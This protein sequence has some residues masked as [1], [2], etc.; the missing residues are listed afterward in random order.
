MKKYHVKKILP[1]IATLFIILTF[2]IVKSFKPKKP[3]IENMTEVSTLFRF[4]GLRNGDAKFYDDNWTVT[5]VAGK[6]TAI[7]FDGEQRITYDDINVRWFSVEKS[8]K[9]IVYSNQDN[10]V[11]ILKLDEDMQVIKN[12]LAFITD[13][14]PIDP[15]IIR[16]NGVYYI[17]VT[18]IDG[19]V[20]NADAL[21]EN[22]LYT[23]QLFSSEDLEGFT[24]IGDIISD[25]RN[26]EDIVPFY[27]NDEFYI[28]YEREELDK[29]NSALEAVKSDDMGASWSKPFVLC[30]AEADNELGSITYEDGIFTMYYSSDCLAKG[31]SY[32]GASIF[33]SR[34]DDKLN[35]LNIGG[36]IGSY[37][38]VLLYDVCEQEDRVLFLCTEKY[39]TQSNL[40]LTAHTE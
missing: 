16:I 13:N 35:P 11:C 12:D 26:L 19:N 29:G 18:L 25:K 21:A 3:L 28:F 39:I 6:F 22:G 24:Y 15:A 2:F 33:V 27:V 14:L 4:N 10:Q 9:T 37:D 36:E 5:S 23:I 20:N 7:S 8:D 38:G 32:E 30:N 40:V 31:T 1:V 34:F 17:T